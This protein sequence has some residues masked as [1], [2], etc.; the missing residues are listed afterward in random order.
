MNRQYPQGH[1]FY[2][3]LH[4][5]YPLIN[6]GQGA[7]LYDTD[8][9]KYLDASGGAAVV[10]IGHGVKEVAGAILSQAQKVG[11]ISGMH[12][13]HLPVENLA[14]QL[15][16][17]LPFS[18]GKVYFLTSG[19]EAIE[20]SI[21][22]ARQYWVEKGQETKFRL[23]SRKPSYH[24][25]TLAA[26][27]VSAR[28]HY[29]DIYQP[30]LMESSKIPAPYCYRCFWEE[31]YPNCQ[32]KCAYELEKNIQKLGKENVS[33]FVT[34]V[35]GGASLGAAVPPAEYFQIVRK[36][37]DEYELLLIVDEVM[38]GAGRTGKWLACHHFDFTPDIIVMGKGI[39]SGYFPLSALA[40]KKD[41]VDSISK[42]GRNFLHAQTY[43]HHPVGC[44]AGLA[45]LDFI[46]KNKLVEKSSKMG[47]AFT[48]E[49]SSLLTHPQVGDIR[50]R[51]LFLGI[52][53]VEDKKSKK[54]FA[55]EKKYVENFL[56]KAME[57]GLILWPNV[58]H[59]DGINGDLILLA[60]PFII[61]K[62]EISQI[63]K[64]L[65]M[66]LEEM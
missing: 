5:S 35:I 7:Y 54:P 25:N 1:V 49:L 24:G 10:N 60:P 26:L 62:K 34:E 39:T 32:I 37:C 3:N 19:S 61:T 40:V 52:E 59:A 21:K 12:F 17:L 8:G 63:S 51:G 14:E 29:K 53:F 28:E 66:V 13:S 50:G 33:A 47:K 16:K 46:K 4:Y 57:R 56:S 64:I 31:E 38:T 45:T 15:S 2:R 30:M 9:K 55:R 58:G 43:S 48:E 65:G 41:I 20:A 44:S 22:L 18:E 6:H 42:A 36:I 11:Y 23:I 27:S